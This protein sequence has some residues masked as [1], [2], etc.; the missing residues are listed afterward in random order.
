[1]PELL[2]N[3]IGGRWTPATATAHVDVFNPAT[4]A[5]IAR[6]PLSNAQ[7]VDRA[8][9]AA[10]GVPEWSETPPVVRARAMFAFKA[11]LEAHFEEIARIVTTEHGKTLDESRGSVR[12]GDRVRRGRVRRA[13]A[14]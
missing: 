1:M 6:T 8:V 5:V 9:R 7:D 3:F 4:G 11:Q 14:C 13:L 2:P 10:A 12:R